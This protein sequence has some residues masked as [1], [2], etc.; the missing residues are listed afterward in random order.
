MWLDRTQ[1]CEGQSH[2]VR[3]YHVIGK[4]RIEPANTLEVAIKILII[5]IAMTIENFNASPY[6]FG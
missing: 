6:H 5:P 1:V 2:T 4:Y 3:P